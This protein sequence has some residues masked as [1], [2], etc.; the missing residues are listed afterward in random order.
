VKRFLN[1]SSQANET[2]VQQG[3]DVCD[4]E[5][6]WSWDVV[7]IPYEGLGVVGEYLQLDP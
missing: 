6:K 4:R 7:K 1:V 2:T 3:E 5:G